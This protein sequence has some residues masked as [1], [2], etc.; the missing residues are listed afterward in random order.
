VTLVLR[1]MDGVAYTAGSDLD[2]DHK[3]I[4]FSLGYIA[5]IPVERCTAEVTGVVTHELVHC[6]QWNALG[7]CPGGLVEGIADWVRLGCGLEPPHWQ[8]RAVADRWDA[9]YQHTAYFLDYLEGRFGKGTIRGVNQA[10]RELKYK[11]E[12]F[13]T[14]LLGVTVAQLWEDYRATFEEGVLKEGEETAAPPA[15]PE[16]SRP[17]E[18][19]T[20]AA[21]PS[22][23]ARAHAVIDDSS[24]AW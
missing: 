13:W 18:P 9:G 12:A 1:E 17:A 20:P 24:W 22:P 14:A 15:Q 2:G 7:T 4:H 6:Y 16:P 3:E 8:R 10:L 19:A 21:P 23:P 11:D 5:G